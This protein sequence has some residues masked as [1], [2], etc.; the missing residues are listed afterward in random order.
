MLTRFERIPALTA[1]VLA[2]G[3]WIAGLVT[4]QTLTT[5]LSD[6][7]TDAQVPPRTRSC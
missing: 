4:T 6:K 2:V 5:G 1:A 3:L 7:A